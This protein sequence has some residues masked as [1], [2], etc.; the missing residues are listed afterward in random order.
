MSR[1]A[2]R[3]VARLAAGLALPLA[4][5]LALPALAAPRFEVGLV[6]P[7]AGQPVFG[8]VVVGAE[9]RGGEATRVEFW[10]DGRL[11]G[12][13]T[14]PPWRLE[15]DTGEANAPR[16]F[17]VVAYSG[18]GERAEAELATPAVRVDEVVELPLQ[19]IYVTAEHG[20]DPVLDLG[21]D[22]FRVS[23]RGTGQRLVTFERGDVPLTA[24]LLLD[25]STSM[26]GG[27]LAA[28]LAGARA[29]AA[30]MAP[31]DEARLVLFSDQVVAAT[32][33]GSDPAALV[34]GLTGAEA[35]GGSAIHD[36]LLLAL[37]E[38]ERRQGRRVVVLLSDGVD[39]ESVLG[40]RELAQVAGRSPTLL[41]WIRLPS[42]GHGAPERSVWRNAEM[43]AAELAG[44]EGLV[45]ASGG[46]VIPIARPEQAPAA[47]GAILAELRGQYV[48]SWYPSGLRHDGSWRPI[49]LDCR[50]GGVELRARE[51]YF[52][53]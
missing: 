6:S 20:G 2:P 16:T 43:H 47:F 5:L 44:L 50:R 8:R 18:A 37:L 23:E 7:E 49:R 15:V 25:S 38:L 27:S 34:A 9:V 29:F 31:L 53:D 48:L 12:E 33:F 32:P 52:D 19:Q 36:H 51:G 24:I 13:L 41:Y 4:V 46:R 11:A 21:R 26:R 17:R 42:P 35:R 40:T 39:V 22:D 45:R 14:R 30:D 1:H 10:L 28:A 3:L